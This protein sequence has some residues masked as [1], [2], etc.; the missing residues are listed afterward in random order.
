MRFT[1]PGHVVAALISGYCLWTFHRTDDIA[2]IQGK[3]CFARTLTQPLC[4]QL[5]VATK[6]QS[7]GL[8]W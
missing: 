6:R 2:P 4:F 5:E 7:F 1:L 3:R 8:A